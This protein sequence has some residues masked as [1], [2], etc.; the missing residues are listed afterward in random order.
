[1]ESFKG[2]PINSVVYIP[3]LTQPLSFLEKCGAS[4]LKHLE[5]CGCNALNVLEKCG[6][7][8]LKPLEKCEIFIESGF[9][10]AFSGV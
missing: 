4:T 7:E 9:Q 3:I 2:C 1:M 10:K 5:K 6:N 8:A